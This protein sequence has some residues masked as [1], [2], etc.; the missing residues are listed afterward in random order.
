MELELSETLKVNT[1]WNY[2]VNSLKNEKE[3]L[4]LEEANKEG[5][6]M[7]LEKLSYDF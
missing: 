6:L 4:V 1:Q 5:G 2:L 3:Q 7:T